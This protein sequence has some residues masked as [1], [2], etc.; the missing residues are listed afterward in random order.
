ML[1]KDRLEIFRSRWGCGSSLTLV[2]PGPDKNRQLGAGSWELGASSISVSL[3]L[4]V[5]A[6]ARAS[7][8]GQKPTAGNW[9]L[10]AGSWKLG[11]GSWELGAAVAAVAAVAVVAAVAAAVGAAQ[12]SPGEPRRAQES[13]GGQD[14]NE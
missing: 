9:K 4:R 2:L 12:E 8:D 11:A 14:I 13:P 5:L 1:P 10:G 6:D 7:G 3:G